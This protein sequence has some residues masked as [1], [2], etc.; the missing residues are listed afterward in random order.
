MLEHIGDLDFAMTETMRCLGYG[1]MLFLL[2]LKF[3][4]LWIPAVPAVLR[5]AFKKNQVRVTKMEKYTV[6]DMVA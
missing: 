5:M 2:M 4:S 1:G 6:R 3:D